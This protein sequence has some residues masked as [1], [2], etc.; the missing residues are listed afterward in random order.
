MAAVAVPLALLIPVGAFA[1]EGTEIAGPKHDME[2][3]YAIA[4]KHFGE[5]QVQLHS[6]QD[7]A[8]GPVHQVHTFNCLEMTYEKV[9]ESAR[10]PDAFPVAAQD[11][12]GEKFNAESQVAPLAAHACKEHGMPLLEMDW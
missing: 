1:A 9:F 8:S 5:G 2:S 7:G 10:A 3:H 4:S 6:R 12:G 11:G